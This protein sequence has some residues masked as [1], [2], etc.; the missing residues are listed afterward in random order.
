MTDISSTQ[1]LIATWLDEL[2][3][4]EA[5][6]KE[7]CVRQI[8]KAESML[9][10]N[11]LQA[12]S[13]V[14]SIGIFIED[15]IGDYTSRIEIDKEALLV[16]GGTL[17]RLARYEEAYAVSVRA[18]DITK[19]LGDSKGEALALNTMGAVAIAQGEYENALH[20]HTGSL[21]L[22]KALGDDAL[23]AISL[24]NIGNVYLAL[25]DVTNA[26]EYFMQSLLLRE[27]I[28]DEHGIGVSLSN[29]G[30]VYGMMGDTEQA[31]EY[32]QKS[33]TRKITTNNKQG[34]I[35]TLCD[36]ASQYIALDDVERAR[37]HANVARQVAVNLGNRDGES[38]A[39]HLLGLI[40]TKAA[41]FTLALDYFYQALQIRTEVNNTKGVIETILA[42]SDVF[43][44]LRRYNEALTIL[45]DIK[46]RTESLHSLTLLRS[47]HL[48]YS[49]A[50]EGMNEYQLALHH[51]RFYHEMHE[52]V[53]NQH[54]AE[55][56]RNLQ[57]LHQVEY[58]KKENEIY[59]L[60]NIE[61]A[62]AYGDA[63][64]LSRSLSISN[65]ELN[66]AVDMLEKINKQ[67]NDIFGIVVHDL[68]NPLTAIV[69][70]ASNALHNSQKISIDDMV[71]SLQRIKKNADRMTRIIKKMMD[72]F[73]VD[74]GGMKVSLE[75]QDIIPIIDKIADTFLPV[76]AEKNIMVEVMS[77]S[78]A[79]AE[80]DAVVFEEIIDNLLSNAIKFSP[81]GT[82]VNVKVSTIE[83]HINL[84]NHTI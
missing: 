65:A 30:I 55:R 23:T 60:R 72:M 69:L 43:I 83:K 24:M 68:R 4:T 52:K 42:Q 14:S 31:I 59:R 41:E 50:Y 73:S 18:L 20:H 6:V 66:E 33:L 1:S 17:Y 7:F 26:H 35:Q 34:Q 84:E 11:P 25:G 27:Q 49:L 81:R 75:Q 5:D 19:E 38:S 21:T 3:S 44:H 51:S 22:R 37:E 12:E 79:I 32:L 48:Q 70:T 10:S 36:L 71:I 54:S 45:H 80:I 82:T 2:E 13:I 47:L 15:A 8:R 56:L 76:A 28:N 57:I 58:T 67:K 63:E 77:V 53:F 74:S 61:L 40:E 78:H 46:Q 64:K 39:L 62:Q 29:I 9:N 16:R